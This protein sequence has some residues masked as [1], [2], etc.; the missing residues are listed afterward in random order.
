MAEIK[1]LGQGKERIWILSWLVRKKNAK[2]SI[3]KYRQINRERRC[4]SQSKLQY[5]I[6]IQTRQKE[7]SEFFLITL[8]Y[9]TK[10]WSYLFH[11]PEKV[12]VA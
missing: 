1:S 12:E 10:H 9:K 2:A 4:Q 8:T 5:Y 7:L 6:M 3:I 11:I